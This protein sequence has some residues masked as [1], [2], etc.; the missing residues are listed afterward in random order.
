MA[1]VLPSGF[2][3]GNYSVSKQDVEGRTTYHLLDTSRKMDF[4][5]VPDMGNFAYQFKVNGKDVLIP[6]ESIHDYLEKRWF[7][8][9][10]PFLAPWA[11]RIDQDY[12]YFEGKKYLLNNDLGNL[13]HVPPFNLVIHGLL[14]FDT[15]WYV[16]KTGAS[17]S[18]GAF[19]TSRHH[20]FE[21]PD[22]MAQFPFAE[23]YEI[24]Y[25]LKNGKLQ[26]TTR[27]YNHSKSDLP[28]H[29][30]YHPYFRPDGPREDWQVSINARD[31]WK[32][33]SQERLIPTGETEPTGSYLPHNEDFKLGKTFIDDGFSDLVRD[34]QGLAHYWVKGLTQKVEV[35]FGK[36]YNFGHV[37]APVDNT[38]IC[39]EPETGPTNAF[40]LNHQGKFPGLVVLKPDETFEAT[41]WI[42]PSGF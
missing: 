20:F 8:C 26:S 5:V 37:Y 1:C 10:I 11:N 33:D 7:C 39:F 27:V 32:V 24:T 16:V 12:Y 17:N 21:Y 18:E 2:A 19:I 25:R 41:Y 36:G 34:A 4:G 13:L 14:V 29:F 9:G 28:V 42:V 38:L 6:P 3:A 31:H 15:H 23:T 30:G 35:I 40:N 22:L